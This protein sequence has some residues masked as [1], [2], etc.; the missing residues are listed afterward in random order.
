MTTKG[1]TQVNNRLK[2]GLNSFE[3]LGGCHKVSHHPYYFDIFV[4]HALGYECQRCSIKCSIV[5]CYEG[6]GR[7]VLN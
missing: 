2:K 6:G 1:F 4:R 5:M 3:H 7:C